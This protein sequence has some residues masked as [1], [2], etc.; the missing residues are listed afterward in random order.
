MPPIR[1]EKITRTRI[2]I[3]IDIKKEICEY[4][5]ANLNVNQATVA[6]FFNTKYAGLDIQRTTINKIWKDRKKWLA[7][8]SNS[9]TAHT[10][11]QQPV[12]YPKLDKA[13]QMWTSQVVAS[14]IPLTDG[15]LQQKGIEFAENLNI[16]DQLKCANGW[17]YRFK[18]RNSLQK[19][20][21]SEEANS[22]PIESLPAERVRLRA[23]LAKYDAEDIYN[24]D[25][26]GRKKDKSRVSILFCVNATGSHKLR[27]LVIGKHLDNYFCTLDQKILLLIDNAGSHFNTIRLEENDDD[28][29]TNTGENNSDSKQESNQNQNKKKNQKKNSK[30]KKMIP[31]LTNIKLIYLPPNTTAH[32]QPMDAGIIHSFKAKYKKEFCKH[33]ICQFDSG[34]D[35]IEN[36]LNLKE[37][38]DYIAEGWNNITQK[39]IQN[40]WIKTGILPTYNDDNDDDVDE[41]DL[42]SDL[43]DEDIEDY[44][45]NLPNSDDI[46]EYFQML[47]H[48][49]PTEENLTDK[50]IVNL[51][52][53][54]KEGGNL[55]DE[56]ED[57]DDEI[58][59]VSV[60]K[61]VSGLKIFINYF[62]QQD[63][64]EFNIDDLRVFRKYLQIART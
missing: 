31:N 46:I 4:M 8:L 60:K 1:L 49:I 15:I 17:V 12:Q 26:T 41:D 11:Q 10:F 32:L 34:I 37:A 25:E 28:E 64:S 48:E 56:E 5:V 27:P 55:N 54:K 50:E 2:A 61:A 44:L 24:A 47:D 52:Q 39:T 23:L 30:N 9:Q 43:D 38:I 19:V 59:L 40:C 16:H 57:E 18:L 63:N 45:D 7:V 21:F 62:E 14:G 42:E 53:F 22:A 20:N 3:S 6:S 33:I 29:T 13:M 51:V 35:H 36:K 58:P